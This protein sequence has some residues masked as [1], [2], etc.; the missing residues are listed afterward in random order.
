M[1]KLELVIRLQYSMGVQIR[2]AESYTEREGEGRVGEYEIAHMNTYMHAHTYMNKRMHLNMQTHG[3][4]CC[5]T[6]LSNH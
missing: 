6:H 3:S 2:A 1:K 4:I 5:M